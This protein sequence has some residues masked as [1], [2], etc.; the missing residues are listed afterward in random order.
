MKGSAAE[1]RAIPNPLGPPNCP[2]PAADDILWR[3]TLENDCRRARDSAANPLTSRF[4][5]LRY[6]GLGGHP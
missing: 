5:G 4:D 1:Q 3:Q 2:V 6:R